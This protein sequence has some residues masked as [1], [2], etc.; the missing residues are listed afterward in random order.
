MKND[1]QT[2]CYGNATPPSLYVTFSEVVKKEKD[3]KKFFWHQLKLEVS[4]YLKWN[5]HISMAIFLVRR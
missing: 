2:I 5:K 3:E 1:E 4:S